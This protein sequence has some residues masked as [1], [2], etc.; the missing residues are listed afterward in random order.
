[1][2]L[3]YINTMRFDWQIVVGSATVLV[4]AWKLRTVWQNETAG[5]LVWDGSCWRWESVMASKAS[6]E[7]KL[8][9]VADLQRL[10]IVMLDEKTGSRSWLCAERSAFPE[11]W[12]DFRR[13]V[14]S[15]SKMTGGQVAIDHVSG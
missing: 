13:A 4:S 3:W 11:R 8:V 12:M 15:G 1:M 14:Y 9:V 6:D 2:L 10:L 7:L 5:R